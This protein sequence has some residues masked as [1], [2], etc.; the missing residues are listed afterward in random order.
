M[1]EETNIKHF[2]QLYE[3]IQK[4]RAKAFHNVNF[5][6]LNLFWQVGAFIDQKII[7]GSWGDKVVEEFTSWL[8][9]KDPSV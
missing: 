9:E 3:F 5:E 7:G 6:Q 1:N 8:K 2:E 4:A